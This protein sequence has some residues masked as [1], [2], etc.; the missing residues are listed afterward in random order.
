MTKR[1]YALTITLLVA[2]V[3][4]GLILLAR[5]PFI[6]RSIGL[7]S[8]YML[9][10]E[11]VAESFAFSPAIRAELVD[12]Y[13]A[14]ERTGGL[15]FASSHVIMESSPGKAFRGEVEKIAL[16]NPK[17]RI[18]LGDAKENGT[19]L[20][21][22]K[23]IPAVHLL[24]IERGEF[25]L[26]FKGKKGD[27]ALRGLDMTIKDFSPV[28]GGKLAFQGMIFVNRL[29]D[30]NL[31]AVG[32][33]RGQID[34]TSFS[35]DMMG[36]G[37]IEIDF[38]SGS[39]GDITLN[40]VRLTIPIIF[41]KGRIVISEAVAGIGF[42]SIGQ[43][44]HQEGLRNGRITLSA[45]Y[46][47]EQEKFAVDNIN[48]HIPGI[49][50]I[51]GG[52]RTTLKDGMPWSASFESREINFS[53]LFSMVKPFLT[54]EEIKE[55]SIDGTGFLKTQMEGT[56]SGKT[57]TLKGRASIELKQGGVVSPDGSKAAQGINGS[58]IFNFNLPRNE[59]SA[60]FNI[61]LE[62]S[63]GEYLWGKYYKD[64]TQEKSK[65]S[66]KT[67]IALDKHKRTQ[68]RGVCNLFNTGKYSY[69]GSVGADEWL[70][71]LSARDVAVKRIVSLFIAD[72]LGET[73]GAFSG[74]ELDGKLDT[75]VILTSAETRLAARGNIQIKGGS[76][77]L[78]GLSLA[79]KRIDVDAPFDLTNVAE[80]Q[81]VT[82][83][84]EQMSRG[85]I[86]VAGFTKDSYSLPELNI[87]VVA[88]GSDVYIPGRFVLPF[89]DGTIRVRDFTFRN[90][91]G[92]S[93]GLSFAAAASGIDVSRILNDL[94]GLTFPGNVRA[95][96]PEISYQDGELRTQG[97]TVFEIFGGTIEAF[98]IY[99][100]NLLLPSRRIG[101]D[102]TFH[103]I[104]LGKIT[105]TLKIGK[106]TGVVEGFVQDL[107]IEYGQ[108]SR[109]VFE[110]DTVR[111]RCVPRKVSVDAIESIS[112]LG[113][114]SGGI[115]TVLK[116]GIS[117]FFKEYPYS[118]IGIRC[119]LEMD[120]F[121]IRGKI[122][123]GGNEYLIRRAFLRGIDVVN[124][125]PENVVSFKDMQER[126]SRVFQGS[127]NGRP[128]IKVN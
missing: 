23:R 10:Y 105:E 65:F 57:P 94:T 5:T 117:R 63:S 74:I 61:S 44:D 104:D 33:C 54:D 107:V 70:F 18:R 91:L 121:N 52:A 6:I 109:F 46:D 106:I 93:P 128:D 11:I 4:A 113:T 69:S 75:E 80:G 47:A 50:T 34:L 100:K 19:D 13:I 99:A 115:S 116:S 72:Y 55:W 71:R 29:G 41:E 97:R 31:S 123:E 56:M 76:L 40:R 103:D 102:I 24:S 27:I 67:D 7:V 21:F 22:I 87:A 49:G 119:S 28:R 25:I 14:N 62:I 84:E 42:L 92:H 30:S 32:R 35:P 108:P 60:T 1:R 85:T 86:L 111:R 16:Q 17:V 78:P 9:G 45:F 96:F 120:T 126:V 37:I 59:K 43:N 114:G 39:L 53:G 58:V 112:I 124:K 122:V 118:R 110:V 82:L 68:F 51:R 64:L 48:A 3:V 90:V 15:F 125:D 38:E 89:Y 26:S 83:P 127:E 101:G 12:L 73:S 20:S 88:R 77:L 95:R 8:S 36:E 66:S 98:N 79:V 81:G 2:I